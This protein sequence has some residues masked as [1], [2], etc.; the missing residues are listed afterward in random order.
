MTEACKSP[1]MPSRITRFAKNIS[2]THK[3]AEEVRN[4]ALSRINEI[5]GEEPSPEAKPSC[6][7]GRA[8]VLG[9]YED[10]LDAISACLNDINDA[11]T[12]L[13]K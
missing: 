9:H 11:L 13:G 1:E 4:T 8:G 6:A 5:M 12:R 7:P 3:V 2:A 10:E